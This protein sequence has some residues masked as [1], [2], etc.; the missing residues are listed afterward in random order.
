[1][2]PQLAGLCSLVLLVMLGCQEAWREGMSGRKQHEQLG[3]SKPDPADVAPEPEPKILPETYLA[4]GRLAQG[5]GDLMLAVSM[6]RKAIALKQDYVEVYNLLGLVL[7]QLGHHKKADNALITAV[8]FAPDKAYLRNNLAYSYILQRRWA[9][10]EVQL[11]RALEFQPEFARAR[12][13]LGV[14]LARRG[15]YQQA[16]E[17]FL[18]VL[19]PASAHYNLGLMQ[20]MNRR[21]RLA[22]ASFSQALALDPG[23]IAARDALERIATHVRPAETEGGQTGVAKANEKLMLGGAAGAEPAS[24]VLVEPE[25][26]RIAREQDHATSGGAA[27]PVDQAR[28]QDSSEASSGSEASPEPIREPDLP[29]PAGAPLTFEEPSP[30]PIVVEKTQQA[31]A[32]QM[33]PSMSGQT[34][35]STVSMEV[36]AVPDESM[37]GPIAPERTREESAIPML[38]PA[39]ASQ[40]STTSVENPITPDGVL[41][42]AIVAETT[43]QDLSTRTLASAGNKRDATRSA[44]ARVAGDGVSAGVIAVAKTRAAVVKITA[45]VVGRVATWWAGSEGQALRSRLGRQFSSGHEP[46]KDPAPERIRRPRHTVTDRPGAEG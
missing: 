12:V 33:P 5:R 4:A 32:I 24:A 14:V 23:M 8:E 25:R 15:L 13:N 16:M 29:P 26:R 1:M 44:R 39:R 2:K 18:L 22:R 9:D 3:T 21:Y 11:R 41:A 34:P 45:S 17:Q 37:V 42:A 46:V 31:P 30:E 27:A 10:A 35:G 19:P 28:Q 20:E 36:K 40:D 6:Y 7:G 38:L 43:R